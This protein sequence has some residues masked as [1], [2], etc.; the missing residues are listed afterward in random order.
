[1][2]C[3]PIKAHAAFTVVISSGG[4]EVTLCCGESPS[5]ASLGSGW[6]RPSGEE[7]ELLPLKTGKLA[8]SNVAK[9]PPL[10]NVTHGVV[11]PGSSGKRVSRPP[12]S[13]PALRRLSAGGALFALPD[14]ISA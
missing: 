5:G 7:K 6:E 1:M 13:A 3:S 12:A 2:H 9:V 14:C 10:P 8:A 11:A 4:E